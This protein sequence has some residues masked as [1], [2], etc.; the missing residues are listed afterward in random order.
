MTLRAG[1]LLGPNTVPILKSLVERLVDRGH[2]IELTAAPDVSGL[3]AR[4]AE[5]VASLDVLWACGLLTA[6]LVANGC[7]IEVVAAPVFDGELSPVYRSVLVT[8]ADPGRGL[9]RS[10][11]LNDVARSRVAVNEIGSWS[12]YRAVLQEFSVV[13]G[14]ATDDVTEAVRQDLVLTGAHVES[15]R[16]VADERADLAAI[17]H[18]IWD[19]LV[20]NSPSDVEELVVVDRTVDWPAPPFSL[21]SSCPAKSALT[22]DLLALGRAP[23]PGLQAIV[24][25]SADAYAVM[26]E[27]VGR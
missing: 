5:A 24:P 19:W 22:A 10:I 27:A 18:T 20:A 23:T 6:E 25:A 1:T 13:R 11:D 3:G 21:A 26:I 12:G 2:D 17:D 9:G 16:A 15:V 8:R 7:P 4:A 14:H